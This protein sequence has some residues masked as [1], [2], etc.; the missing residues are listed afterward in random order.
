[1]WFKIY[2]LGAVSR[3]DYFEKGREHYIRKEYAEAVSCFL[4]SI[5]EDYYNTP[6]AG[7]GRCYECGLGVAKDRVL[8][9]DLSQ[10]AM[11]DLAL[12]KGTKNLGG[13]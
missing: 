1:M 7:L 2:L 3:I 12:A 9:K 8:A 13:G 10:G 6:R 11:I 4:R 5:T